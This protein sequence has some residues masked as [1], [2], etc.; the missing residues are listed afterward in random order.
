MS[1]YPA[2]VMPQGPAEGKALAIAE[3]YERRGYRIGDIREFRRVLAM[4]SES[5]I[6][7]AALADN[8]RRRLRAPGADTRS[9]PTRQ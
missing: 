8:A 7:H 4:L 3:I 5:E 1:G 2:V 6:S 9:A